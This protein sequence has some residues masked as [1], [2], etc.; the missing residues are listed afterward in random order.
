[1]EMLKRSYNTCKKSK[2]SPAQ[3]KKKSKTSHKVA[4]TGRHKETK[5]NKGCRHL[6]DNLS[7]SL[8]RGLGSHRHYLQEGFVPTRKVRWSRGTCTGESI[9]LN[10]F[11]QKNF[12]TTKKLQ[13]YQLGTKHQRKLVLSIQLCRRFLCSPEK[14][15]G[16][17]ERRPN[18]RQKINGQST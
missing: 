3:K 4:W 11:L 2:T 18:G 12:P 6:V 14:P 16:T 1:M 8:Y 9:S 7:D 5:T 17:G 15:G 13:W 10:I